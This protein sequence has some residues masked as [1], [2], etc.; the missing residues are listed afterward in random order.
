MR[1]LSALGL[2]AV[3][4]LPACGGSSPSA[5]ATPPSTLAS[6]GVFVA[7]AS[8]NPIIAQDCTPALCG[9]STNRYAAV[10]AV[11]VAESAGLGGNIDFI[12]V[13]LRNATTGVEPNTLN[14]GADEI[15][16]RAGGTN[17]V[18][19]SGSL[20]VKDIGAL[21]TLALGGRQATMTIA[22]Q[23]TDDRANRSNLIVTVLVVRSAPRAPSPKWDATQ[24]MSLFRERLL[25][26][27]LHK[28]A[29]S[30]ALNE[31]MMSRS[32]PI[33]RLRVFRNQ[34]VRGSIPGAGSMFSAAARARFP[35][36]RP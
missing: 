34:Q 11:T 25:A 29:I 16:R 3:L 5:P 26:R 21:Y 20:T 15:A 8:P 9:E 6:R 28:R 22:V 30:R 18:Q 35:R 13:T 19:G 4:S 27:L 24:L 32:G 2:L 23:V 31:K 17:H 1:K 12:N 10:T 36:R 14:Y 33:A 7:T